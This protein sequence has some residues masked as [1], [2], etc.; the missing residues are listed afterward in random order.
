LL[1]GPLLL[2]A[3]A[4]GSAPATAPS[5]SPSAS[6]KLAPFKER[7]AAAK[8]VKVETSIL[9][10]EI[11]FTLEQAHARLD[12]LGEPAKPSTE[13][14]EDAEQGEKERRI[15]WHLARSD[16]S[17]VFVKADEQE[18]ITYIAAFVRP[19][20][21]ISFDKIGQTEKAPILTDHTVAWDVVRPNQPLI[22]VVAR[23]ENR[24]ASSITVFLV[25]RPPRP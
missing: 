20:K 18:R 11:G 16:F 15:I 8:S 3:G 17:S 22:R 24:T 9:G 25:K 14:T 5:P 7:L 23:G 21:E 2:V 1:L 10:L 6:P 12:S 13:A 4:A 19:G